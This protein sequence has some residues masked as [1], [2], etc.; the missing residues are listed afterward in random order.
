MDEREG[1]GAEDEPRSIRLMRRLGGNVDPE[2]LARIRARQERFAW[3]QKWEAGAV[4]AWAVLLLVL[5]LLWLA[6]L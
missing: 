4:F 5:G 1:V 6:V 3:V 2:V